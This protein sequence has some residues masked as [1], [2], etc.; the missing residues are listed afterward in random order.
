M[1]R[2]KSGVSVRAVHHEA[3]QHTAESSRR[4]QSSSEASDGVEVRV[5]EAV[6]AVDGRLPGISDLP[7]RLPQGVRRPAPRAKV[8]GGVDLAERLWVCQLGV[9]DHRL[10]PSYVLQVQRPNAE[11]QGILVGLVRFKEEV[12][13]AAVEFVHNDRDLWLYLRILRIRGHGAVPQRPKHLPL[14]WRRNVDLHAVDA[15]LVHVCRLVQQAMKRGSKRKMLHRDE[16][17]G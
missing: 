5:V 6:V 14:A 1:S 12:H 3:V 10:P 13:V 2:E 8:A 9:V 15:Y 17:V 4:G 11:H 7:R 16:R